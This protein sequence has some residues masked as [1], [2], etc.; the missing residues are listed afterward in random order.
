MEHTQLLRADRLG[1]SDVW[2]QPHQLVRVCCRRVLDV[3]LDLKYTPSIWLQVITPTST[4]SERVL[5][6]TDG[7]DNLSSV[8]WELFGTLVLA[9][10]LV[11]FIIWKGLN[12]SGYVSYF[13]Q[14]LS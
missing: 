2:D 6:I 14:S 8:R 4:C 9:W 10:I 3:T 11:Y 1:E 5:G 13:T 12:E 7:I